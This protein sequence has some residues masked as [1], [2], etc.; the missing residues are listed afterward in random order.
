M[1][2]WIEVLDGIVKLR[3]IEGMLYGIDGDVAI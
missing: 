3:D 2:S 1:N